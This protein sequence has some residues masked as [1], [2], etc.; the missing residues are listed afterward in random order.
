MNQ[1]NTLY[2]P[3]YSFHDLTQFGINALTGESCGFGLRMLCDVTE[4]G[5]SLL[6]D[7]FG[8]ANLDLSPA[9]NSHTNGEPV[10]GSIM[11]SHQLLRPLAEFVFFTKGALA[12][13]SNSQEVMG[14]FTAEEVALY[15]AKERDDKASLS[16]L[17]WRLQY[18]PLNYRADGSSSGSRHQHAM[19][20]R[21]N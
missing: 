14:L 13:M 5:K 15:E 18:K 11:L 21:I 8:C 16:P 1:S 4:Q 17:N 19:T 10:V 6:T 9:W 3:V 2:R 20:A 12:I 7:Y